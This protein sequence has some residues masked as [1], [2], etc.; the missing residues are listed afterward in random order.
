MLHLHHFQST[1]G[2]RMVCSP[3]P[4]WWCPTL[5][6]IGL[7]SISP[8]WVAVA[9]VFLVLK[10]WL[11]PILFRP[12]AGSSTHLLVIL[13]LNGR[14]ITQDMGIHLMM[15]LM[16]RST[17]TNEGP[18][19]LTFFCT[20]S[21]FNLKCWVSKDFEAYEAEHVLTWH[22]HLEPLVTQSISCP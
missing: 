14:C 6:T 22:I 20:R 4:K 17:F 16:M 15:V 13:S 8:K 12:F 21:C 2:Y 9:S 3:H 18:S 5:V 11:D 1:Y 19:N 10:K 7:R